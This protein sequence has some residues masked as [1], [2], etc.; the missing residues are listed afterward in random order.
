MPDVALHDAVTNEELGVN[1]EPMATVNDVFRN[2][3]ADD[4][5]HH[6]VIDQLLH[7]VESGFLSDRQLRKL[8]IMRRDGK[9][10]LYKDCPLSKLL[11][12]IMLLEFKSTN[13]LNDKAFD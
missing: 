3:L 7:N 9:T 5:L 8:E 2:T 4:T 1:T 11:A 12:D 6:N 13:R 10:P